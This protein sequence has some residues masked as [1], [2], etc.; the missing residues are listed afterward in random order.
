[1]NRSLDAWPVPILFAFLLLFLAKAMA[2]ERPDP[3]ASK[4]DEKTKN[5]STDYIPDF[6]LKDPPGTVLKGDSLYKNTGMLVMIT[7][8]NLTQYERQKRWEGLMNKYHWPERNAPQRVLIEDLS[9]QVTYKEKARFM[10]KKYYKPGGDLVVL[11]DE[12]GDVRRGFGV[13]NNETNIFLCD[14]KGRI[15]HCVADDV[16][17]DEDAAKRII[18]EVN[19]LA[20]ANA[21]VAASKVKSVP[22]TLATIASPARK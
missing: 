11:I 3:V 20:D 17:P 10:M 8:P 21:K 5:Q 4:V 12:N 2:S 1:M 9:Q 13:M 22:L 19:H 6:T 14:T 16:E 15:L 7:V 18:T